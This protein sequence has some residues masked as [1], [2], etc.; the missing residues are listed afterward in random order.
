ME[1]WLHYLKGTLSNENV[2][3]SDI[4]SGNQ[5]LIFSLFQCS[6]LTNLYNGSWNKGFQIHCVR[7][8]SSIKQ[9][10]E[11]LVAIHDFRGVRAFSVLAH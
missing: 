5:K 3:V 1:T 2:A 8:K 7:Q 4:K 6:D 11:L 9:D 10:T